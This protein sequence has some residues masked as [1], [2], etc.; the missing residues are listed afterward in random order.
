MF[1]ASPTSLCWTSGALSAWCLYSGYIIMTQPVHCVAYNGAITS[2]FLLTRCLSYCMSKKC[3]Y[4]NLIYTLGQD[5]LDRQY[6]RSNVRTEYALH[7]I[8]LNKLEFTPKT[9]F[10]R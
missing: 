2:L 5:F 8:I 10:L 9:Y 4:S 3:L 6:V 1:H 7:Y